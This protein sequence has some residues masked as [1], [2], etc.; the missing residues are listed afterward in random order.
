MT[1]SCYSHDD[2]SSIE[3]AYDVMIIKVFL[4]HWVQ[5]TPF[6]VTLLP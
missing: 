4:S 5:A 2:Y 6:A 1:M 3:A